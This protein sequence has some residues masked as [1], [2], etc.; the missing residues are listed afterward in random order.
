VLAVAGAAV[1]GWAVQGRA[2]AESAFAREARLALD[3]AEHIRRTTVQFAERAFPAGVALHDF[4]I[5]TGADPRVAF[6]VV[7]SA[8][9]VFDLRQ[10]R[11]GNRVAVGRSLDGELRALRYKIDPERLLLVAAAGAPGTADAEFRAEIKL[12]PAISET[13]AVAGVVRGSLFEGVVDAGEE[14]ELAI[15]LADIFGWDL[16]FHSDPRRGDTF[17]VAVERRKYPG[18]EVRYTKIVAAEYVNAGKPYQAVLFR[19]GS[20]KAAYYAPDG[21][22]LQKAFLRSPLKF[23]API[24]SRFSRSRFHPILRTHRPHLGIDYSAPQG[25]P[26]QAI[27]EGRVVFAGYKGGAGNTVHIRHSNGYETMYLHLSRIHVRAGSRVGQGE[28]IGR[29]GSTGLSTAPHLDFRI[30]QNGAYRN[31]AALNLPPAEPVARSLRKEFA[32]TRQQA[33]AQLPMPQP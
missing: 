6:R 15:L 9:Q 22:S 14:P 11:A 24:T 18:G 20:G 31:F 5:R 19:D 4:L 25:S 2:A 3:Q 29:V 33:L 10:I 7:Q 26:V 1:L 21:S 32:A 27:G 23:S 13:V 12:T 17:R 8:Q 16:D 30:T 28:I